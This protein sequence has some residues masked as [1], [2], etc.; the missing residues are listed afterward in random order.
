MT[1]KDGVHAR[2]IS[3]RTKLIFGAGLIAALTILTALATA[4]EANETSRQISRIEQAQARIEQLAEISGRVSDYAITAVDSATEDFST[5][6]ATERLTA[7][8]NAV[9]AAFNRSQKALHGTTEQE[10]YS[11]RLQSSL[12]KMEALFRSMDANIRSGLLQGAAEDLS[13]SLN[14][15][16]GQ[17]APLLGTSINAEQETR[18]DA[19]QRI[20]NIRRVLTT[21]SIAVVLLTLFLL[22]LF[23]IRIIGPIL[24]RIGRVG[25]ATKSI[26]TGDFT[27]NLPT[28][29]A[30]ELG[31]L[32]RRTNVMAAE[33]GRNKIKVENDRVRLNDTIATRTSELI[34]ANQRLSQ[35]DAQRRRF[36]A[37]VS[38][39]LRTPLTVILAEAELSQNA[40]PEDIEESLKV[41][42]VRAGKLNQRIDDLLRI[43]R[44][45]SGKIELDLRQAELGGITT[46]A[47]E[48]MMPRL[49]KKGI[50]LD[51]RIEAAGKIVTDKNWMR[52]IICGLIENALKH[53]PEGSTICVAVTEDGD[54]VVLE[55][56]DQ[57]KG[58]DPAVK[59]TVFDRF[60][61]GASEAGTVG[62]GIGLSLA[63]WVVEEH[64]GVIELSDAAGNAKGLRVSIRL[65]CADK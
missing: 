32:F 34:A 51:T 47:I 29:P 20:G 36:F 23:N 7:K 57:G 56:S 1:A 26:A 46:E 38:H 61:K 15:F 41:I 5:T 52:Q 24:S 6:R 33:L 62:F 27:I 16:S 9:H 53:T 59:Q 21:L 50:T 40:P 39:E 18:Q 45:D 10:P 63:K 25:E 22:I 12:E 65:P 2:A 14:M 13:A 60:S 4:Y 42:L 3:I 55:I 64:D 49:R 43:A 37:D 35:I 28:E 31:V 54:E 8:A 17:F 30:D 48:D 11:R 58:L 19:V 44:S